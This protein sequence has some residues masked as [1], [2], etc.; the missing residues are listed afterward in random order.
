LVQFLR[1]LHTGWTS[2]PQASLV[3]KSP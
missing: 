3:R 1:V 2:K